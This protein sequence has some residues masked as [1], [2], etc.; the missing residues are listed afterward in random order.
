MRLSLTRLNGI[1]D[2][3]A[4]KSGGKARRSQTASFGG[5]LLVRDGSRMDRMQASRGPRRE[6]KFDTG[7]KICV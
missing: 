3:K 6:S 5:A 1:D 2:T 7:K 4:T